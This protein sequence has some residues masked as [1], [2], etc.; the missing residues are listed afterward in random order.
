MS[1][2]EFVRW[3]LLTGS[4]LP[5]SCFSAAVIWEMKDASTWAAIVAVIEKGRLVWLLRSLMFCLMK[6]VLEVI[7]VVGCAR[8]D[9]KRLMRRSLDAIAAKICL[10]VLE[11]AGAVQCEW[12][13]RC[14]EFCSVMGY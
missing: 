10:Y 12:K 5:V 9:E 8:R 7:R 3:V 4:S 1:H 11:M 6:G 13:V 14:Y 2:I